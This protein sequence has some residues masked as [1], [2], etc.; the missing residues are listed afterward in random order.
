MSLLW[1]DRLIDRIPLLLSLN[2]EDYTLVDAVGVADIADGAVAEALNLRGP[3]VSR[4]P[5]SL[6][7]LS[8]VDFAV[9][10]VLVEASLTIVN[11]V[12]SLVC[13]DDREYLKRLLLLSISLEL[14]MGGHWLSK[15]DPFTKGA[16]FADLLQLI[17]LLLDLGFILTLALILEPCVQDLLLL[18]G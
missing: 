14:N 12:D 17:L 2:F 1:I 11:D 6:E 13:Q 18:V 7:F 16:V 9:I 3:F 8:W 10:W 5:H 4:L 15:Q